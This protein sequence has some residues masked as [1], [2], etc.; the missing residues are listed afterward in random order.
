[1]GQA[2]SSLLLTSSRIISRFLIGLLPLNRP[3]HVLAVAQKCSEDQEYADALARILESIAPED[4][5][6]TEILANIE[7][8]LQFIARLYP[9]S[10][11][12]I[13]NVRAL[14]GVVAAYLLRQLSSLLHFPQPG[15]DPDRRLTQFLELYMAL[16]RNPVELT[17]EPPQEGDGAEP[18][19]YPVPAVDVLLSHCPA[20]PEPTAALS[21]PGAGQVLLGLLYELCE[22]HNEGGPF[23]PATRL[24]DGS[25]IPPLLLEMPPYLQGRIPAEAT[26]AMFSCTKAVETHM[27]MAQQRFGHT[28]SVVPTLIHYLADPDAVLHAVVSGCS[29]ISPDQ[30]MPAV[31]TGRGGGRGQTVRGCWYV[32]HVLEML[33]MAPPYLRADVE[34]ASLLR[35]HRRSA[36]IGE[37]PSDLTHPWQQA[38]GYIRA[39]LCEDAVPQYLSSESPDASLTTLHLTAFCQCRSEEV[40]GD[41]PYRVDVPCSSRWPFPCVDGE[42]VLEPV[43]GAG[44]CPYCALPDS[45]RCTMQQQLIRFRVWP[46]WFEWIQMPGFTSLPSGVLAC[47]VVSDSNAFLSLVQTPSKYLETV[48][49]NENRASA[50]SIRGGQTDTSS[51]AHQV[52]GDTCGCAER[53]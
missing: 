25:Y 4:A 24:A 47:A 51:E 7:R 20:G 52:G 2:N 34:Y 13:S 10:V 42:I 22:T 9:R 37:Y 43:L 33:G 35:R 36:A 15:G 39:L 21:R 11:A 19:S 23:F 28:Y 29:V 48:V 6:T 14:R 1:M 17:P 32:L 5:S 18:G 3:S 16:A 30:P 26:W 38:W 53:F 46:D 49:A 45:I 31:Y 27:S 44:A 12:A 41:P 8:F 40:R 50:T